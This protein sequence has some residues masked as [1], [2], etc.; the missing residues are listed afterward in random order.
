LL[1]PQPPP[2]NLAEGGLF[3]VFKHFPNIL[4]HDEP[5]PEESDVR[6]PKTLGQ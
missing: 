1:P 3:S 6:P 2:V 4:R 5:E